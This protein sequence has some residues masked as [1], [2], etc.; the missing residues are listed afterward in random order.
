MSDTTEIALATALGEKMRT[1]PLSKITVTELTEAVGINRQTFY[2]HF[3]DVE[4]LTWWFFRT[5]LENVFKNSSSQPGE[6]WAESLLKVFDY[7]SINKDI[8][9]NAVSSD[10][11]DMFD[12]YLKASIENLLLQVVKK[13]E[14]ALNIKLSSESE[15][16]LLDF[17][18]YP[19]AYETRLWIKKGM[20]YDPSSKI[21]KMAEFFEADIDTNIKVALY[22]EKAKQTNGEKQHD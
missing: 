12:Y 20:T 7:A 8:I 15:T 10:N 13:R 11:H 16:D 17:V 5:S 18:T 9:L 22:L 2:Y 4:S 21:L 6:N 3:K 1:K 14:Q 19:F